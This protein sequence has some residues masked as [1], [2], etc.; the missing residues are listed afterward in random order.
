MKSAL[1]LEPEGDIVIDLTGVTEDTSTESEEAWI[2]IKPKAENV[3]VT[4]KGTS[5][6][7]YNLEM[8][9][10]EKPVTVVMDNFSTNN[11]LDFRAGGASIVEYSGSSAVDQIIFGTG[12]TAA[13]TIH[14]KNAAGDSNAHLNLGWVYSLFSGTYAS[15]HPESKLILE[16]DI[17]IGNYLVCPNVTI[18]NAEISFADDDDRYITAKVTEIT[19]STIRNV[20]R[21][22][23]VV[24]NNDS[25]IFTNSPISVS[26]ST[27]D[28]TTAANTNP[29]L[30]NAETITIDNSKIY[31]AKIYSTSSTS[32][33]DNACIGGVFETLT[34][35]NH[36]EVYAESE[37]S[38]AIGLA[39]RTC[40]NDTTYNPITTA[41]IIIVDSK[42][43]AASQNGAAIGMPYNWLYVNKDTGEPNRNV[44]LTIAISGDSDIT[45]TSIHSA[46]IGGGRV[47]TLT[48]SDDGK[49]ELGIGGGGIGGWGDG[50]SIPGDATFNSL[51]ANRMMA[52]RVNNE[53]K[54]IESAIA[55]AAQLTDNVTI[56]I[57]GRP[58]I[59]A[60]SGVL[61]VYGNTVTCNDT[62]LVQN[63]MV[64]RQASGSTYVL[65]AAENPGTVTIG[66]ESLGELGYGYASAASTGMN[67]QTNVGMK[68][69]TAQLTDITNSFTEFTVA[70]NGWQPFFTT[71]T[72]VLSGTVQL[73]N[74]SGSMPITGSATTNTTLKADLS[75]LS[76]ASA[77]S[78]SGKVTY[79]WYRNGAKITSAT[80]NTY[81]LTADDK[82]KVIYCI[83]TGTGSYT[84]SVTSNAA[85]V[86][87]ASGTVISAPE[88]E[89]RTETSIILKDAGSDY[90]YS[91]DFGKTWQIDRTFT[92]LT[93]GQTY[94]FIQKDGVGNISSAANFSTLSDAPLLSEFTFNYATERMIFPSGVEIY[95][96]ANCTGDSIN[97]Y[98]SGLSVDIS[99]YISDS[100]KDPQKLY[101]KYVSGTGTTEITVPCRPPMTPLNASDVFK[102]S[103]SISFPGAAG[104]S[105]QLEQNGN[106]IKPAATGDGS[107]IT[108]DGLTAGQTYTLKMRVEAS[109]SLLSPHFHSDQYDMEISIPQTSAMTGT[110]LVPANVTGKRNYNLSR[111]LGGTAMTDVTES[112]DTNNMISAP[113]FTGTTLTF[114]TA[115]VKEEKTA[116]L[117]VT[118]GSMT[119]TLTVK[120][121]DVV[122]ESNGVLWIKP[123]YPNA[124]YIDGGMTDQDITDAWF[125]KAN[126]L[127]YPT[128]GMESFALRPLNAVGGDLATGAQS[129]T[130]TWRPSQSASVTFDSGNF[131]V[132][133]IPKS[134]GDVQVPDYQRGKDALTFMAE[135]QGG[136]YAVL[137][138]S[139][140]EIT[141]T[142]D[143]KLDGTQEDKFDL[144]ETVVVEII[145]AK[146][147]SSTSISIPTG[148]VSTYLGDPQSG[149][150][151]LGSDVLE[152]SDNGQISIE[153]TVT[154]DV[155]KHEQAQ[156]LYIVYEGDYNYL[157]QTV[158]KSVTFN[159]I[160]P[161][162]PVITAQPGDGL[163]TISWAKPDENGSPIT[164]YE[165]SVTQNGTPI[166]GSPIT[167]DPTVTSYQVTG[168]ANGTNY[169]FTLTAIN[170]VGTSIP[171]AAVTATPQTAGGGHTGGSGGSSSGS[172]SSSYRDREYDFWM[173]VKDLIEDANPGD[174]VKAN[175]RSYDRMPA[176]VMRALA[177]ADGVTL[178][179]T[180][181][182]GEDIVIPSEA[183]LSESGRI[184]Y[185]L[186]YL[187]K[188]AFTVASE[189]PAYDPGKLNPETGGIL[190]VTAPVADT[191][192]TPAG[193]PEVTAPNQGLIETPGLAEE[194][195]EQVIPSINESEE[196]VIDN[197]GEES[198]INGFLI[199]GLAVVLAAAAGCG[200]WYW[201]R[202]SVQ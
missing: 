57:T 86:T 10:W 89:S 88:L 114:V 172:G 144:G 68:F 20:K 24:S 187:E 82:N 4:V 183:A 90:Q 42:I 13:Q 120:T 94:T 105:Y 37:N 116:T 136:L 45:A 139:A 84:G 190:E 87:D 127:G 112:S 14:V 168:L 129:A 191:V 180:W 141:L 69:G 52:P 92:G 152:A 175:A 32:T 11:I 65:Y 95:D 198:G 157:P 15:A 72:L 171:S 23:G 164:N 40:S 19:N 149:G 111:W 143:L 142:A 177:D 6:Q 66:S 174:T 102:T 176:S 12:K 113:E 193:Q 63:T 73:V 71:P 67:E 3:T 62:N 133:H 161:A 17:Q 29:A 27:I 43:E 53:A 59:T 124:G 77:Q 34:I 51:R 130:I 201:K 103:N 148:R 49:I 151:L 46:A 158:Q 160:A 184:Y 146:D 163:V 194:G 60:K 131:V 118:A 80:R 106:V 185:P 1:V 125:A 76:P 173:K 128:E 70:G 166:S 140:E 75:G 202:R 7:I 79:Q 98:V 55:E 8:D 21:I 119:L 145:V 154:E 135:N 123:F 155:I 30:G 104:V 178:H 85:T 117:I 78:G 58:T 22:A 33:S 170:A 93:E 54:Q 196:A 189:A 28:F 192:P 83:V 165:R 110:I 48:T 109:N 35:T 31:N 156:N 167:I 50:G 122:A 132:L 107:T 182:G 147:N 153:Y 25:E 81:T 5:G 159:A 188:I 169:S 200:F 18:Q 38:A 91:I 121:V 74:N 181:N 64:K 186:S 195:I 41:S 199:A 99:K 61:A 115:S 26:G 96:N 108:F 179:I 56:T 126:E 100:D 44:P 197:D 137:Y 39:Q 162:Q 134:G 150:I 138:K 9:V 101:A 47:G 16:G 36:S 97:K 2:S